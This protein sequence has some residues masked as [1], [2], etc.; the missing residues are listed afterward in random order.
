MTAFLLQPW[1]GSVARSGH[2]AP[3]P[4]WL[5]RHEPC[6]AAPTAELAPAIASPQSAWPG[7]VAPSGSDVPVPACSASQAP[8][9]V[10]PVA[11]LAPASAFRQQL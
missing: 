1:P 10:A 3:A 2:D 9:P 7:S 5:A 8:G 6:R 4:A 11:G